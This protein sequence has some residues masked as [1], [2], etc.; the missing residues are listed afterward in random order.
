MNC[1]NLFVTQQHAEQRKFLPPF[2]FGWSMLISNKEWL[3]PR[4]DGVSEFKWQLCVDVF[5]W[6]YISLWRIKLSLNELQ[7]ALNLHLLFVCHWYAN[8]MYT[9]KRTRTHT[10]DEVKWCYSMS[11]TW[12]I[13]ILILK[14][15]DLASMC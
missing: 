12:Q 4:T 13:L 11:I 3:Q 2:I 1:T 5:I 7:S 14:C 8:F 6:I 10:L 15:S 9:H